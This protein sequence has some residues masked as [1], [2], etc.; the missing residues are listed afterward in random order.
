MTRAVSRFMEIPVDVR[1]GLPIITVFVP[2]RYNIQC[3]LLS[4]RKS[5]NI[6]TFVGLVLDSFWQYR[7]KAGSVKLLIVPTISDIVFPFPISVSIHG[8]TFEANATA[9][10]TLEFLID[11]RTVSRDAVS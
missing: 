7:I 4:P 6:F 1:L 5:T 11:R 2:A 10:S 8:S 9:I 3:M